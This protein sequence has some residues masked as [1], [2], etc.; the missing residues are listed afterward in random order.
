MLNGQ[1]LPLVWLGIVIAVAVGVVGVCALMAAGGIL[2]WNSPRFAAAATPSGPV[3]AVVQTSAPLTPAVKSTP[4]V[5]ELSSGQGIAGI[6][7]DIPIP[8]N[9]ESGAFVGGPNSFSFFTDLSYE[10]TLVF[11]QQQLESLEWVKED[12]GTKLG[13]SG[14]ELHYA[15]DERRLTVQIARLPYVGTVVEIVVQD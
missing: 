15:K 5:A 10:D 12:Y 14:A 9:V 6:A 8:A 13:R 1:R 11:Y 4:G 7:A 2:F 3:V